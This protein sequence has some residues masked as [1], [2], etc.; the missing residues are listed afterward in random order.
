MKK[1][2]GMALLMSVAVAAGVMQGCGKKEEEKKI[3]EDVNFPLA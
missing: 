3:L 1:M 2:R